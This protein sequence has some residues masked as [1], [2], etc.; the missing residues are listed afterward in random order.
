[1]RREDLIPAAGASA[2][3]ILELMAEALE[4][5]GF[6]AMVIPLSF[7]MAGGGKLPVIVRRARARRYEDKVGGLLSHMKAQM[8]KGKDSPLLSPLELLAEQAE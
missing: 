1:M 3:E 6:Q 7:F 2:D 5:L 4:N 8:L